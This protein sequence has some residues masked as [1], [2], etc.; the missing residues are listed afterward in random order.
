[1]TGRMVGGENVSGERGRVG[2]SLAVGAVKL[3]VIFLILLGI[4]AGLHS[5]SHGI[6]P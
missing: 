3:F 5:W 6:L 4:A 1:M 2:D